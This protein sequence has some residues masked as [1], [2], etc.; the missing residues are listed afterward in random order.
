MEKLV[1][2]VLGVVILSAP[3]MV[4]AELE[5]DALGVSEGLQA[6]DAYQSKIQYFEQVF[7]PSSRV[8]EIMKEKK[9]NEMP[10][11]RNVKGETNSSSA[12]IEEETNSSNTTNLVPTLIIE[13]QDETRSSFIIDPNGTVNVRELKKYVAGE[14][15]DSKVDA[16]GSDV[17]QTVMTISGKMDEL[18]NKAED[19][20]VSFVSDSK[21]QK[22]F[23][24]LGN[25]NA[26]VQNK[27]EVKEG[28]IY[29]GE[30][31]IKVMP[32]TASSIAINKLQSNKNVEIVLKDT[33][34]DGYSRPVYETSVEKNG[35]ILGIFNSSVKIKATVDAENGEV[36]KVSRPW[37]SVFVSFMKEESK[38]E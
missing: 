4:S 36:I 29:S 35:K 11:E 9:E 22:T 1:Y 25:V 5:S 27:I 30:K 13:S 2:L 26:E 8:Y 23:M 32:D 6:P 21:I 18:G 15:S 24:V 10:A 12:T 34:K 38:A 19:K 31:E 16:Q 7:L 14:D 37:W 33:G 17:M 3:L 20:V 28:K